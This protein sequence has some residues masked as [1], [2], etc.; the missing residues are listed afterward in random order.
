MDRLGI[1]ASLV[2]STHALFDHPD[3]GNRRLMADIAPHQDRLY[4]AWVLLPPLCGD[5]TT[6]AQIVAEMQQAGAKAA[7]LY[8]RQQGYLLLPHLLGDLPAALEAAH[9][10]LFLHVGMPGRENNGTPTLRAG[11]WAGLAALCSAHPRLSVVLCGCDG[12]ERTLWML[13][14]QMPNLSIELSGLRLPYGLRILECGE[15]DPAEQSARSR[16]ILGTGLPYHD[17]GGA[18]GLI[19]WGLRQKEDHAAI[20]GENLRRLLN[21]SG[22]TEQAAPTSFAADASSEA[23]PS[24]FDV[25][26][27]CGL[28]DRAYVDISAPEDLVGAMDRFGIA[29]MA[30]ADFQAFGADYKSGNCRAAAAASQFPD[31]LLAC[32]VYNPNCEYE[33]EAEITRCLELEQMAGLVL[34]GPRHEVDTQDARNMLAFQMADRWQ[35]PVLVHPRGPLEPTFLNRLLATYPRLTFVLVVCDGAQ[36]SWLHTLLD[37][38]RRHRNLVFNLS[39]VSSQQGWIAWLVGQVGPTQI[40]FGSGFPLYHPAYQLGRVQ[41]SDVCERDRAHIL[42]ANAARIFRVA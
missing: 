19:H 11:E 20:A 21:L 24:L 31:R 18:L 3:E 39:A 2:H 28:S 37:I 26:G 22:T 8:P 34:H 36:R 9:L 5:T 12:S 6:P 42:Y 13:W 38:A 17:P 35:V 1:A 14:S 40:V 41:F 33:M 29:R 10:P 15:E 32:A 30:M 16:L 7:F 23:Q 25:Q 27:Y 4:P